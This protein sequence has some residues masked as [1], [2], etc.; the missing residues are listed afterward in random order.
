M[1]ARGYKRVAG[2]WVVLL[3]TCGMLVVAAQQPQDAQSS[4]AG[5]ELV[6]NGDFEG[7]AN[8]EVPGGWFKAMSPAQTM[9]LHAG[10]EKAPGRGNVASIE[11]AG[12]KA[13]LCNNW[14]QRLHTIPIGATVRVTAEV[15][16]ENV[17]A[18][19][20]FIMVQC[21]DSARHL[22]IGASSLSVQPIGGTEDWKPVSFEFAVPQA[23]RTIILRCGL[24][25]SG[26]ISFDNVSLQ[27]VTPA[28]QTLTTPDGFS[29]EGFEVTE[30]SLE[31]LERVSALS[32]ELV[33]YARQQLGADIGIRTEVFA[34]GGGRFQVVLLLDWSK[35]Q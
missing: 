8:G 19:T 24:T 28:A 34:Q 7:S 22:I 1:K 5:F 25:E 31:R 11:Q 21:W 33:R 4:A 3:G 35:A 6:V 14:A 32:D 10:L 9:D 29:A 15:K 18:N 2:A 30:Q 27:V 17:P 26:K 23:T 16:T 13:P 12:V 20:G